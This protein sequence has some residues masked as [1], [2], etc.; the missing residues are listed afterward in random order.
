MLHGHAMVG[1]AEDLRRLVHERRRRLG[2]GRVETTH[3]VVHGGGTFAIGIATAAMKV[4]V[5]RD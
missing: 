5:Q 3:V 4:Q 1:V 2:H